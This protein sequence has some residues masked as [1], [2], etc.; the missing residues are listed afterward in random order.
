MLRYSDGHLRLTLTIV[1]SNKLPGISGNN[2]RGGVAA[3]QR[4]AI[5]E[6]LRTA[7][8]FV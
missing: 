1:C 4:H 6:S 2:R 8:R 5:P 7:L 3:C